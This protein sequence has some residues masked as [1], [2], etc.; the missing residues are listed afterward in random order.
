MAA[1]KNSAGLFWAEIL[2]RPNRKPLLL[3]SPMKWSVR[4]IGVVGHHTRVLSATFS[5]N[6][7]LEVDFKGRNF[8]ID[9]FQNQRTITTL[10]VQGWQWLNE[11]AH[12]LPPSCDNCRRGNL[13][14][15][16]HPTPWRQDTDINGNVLHIPK[17]TGQAA[18]RHERTLWEG[19]AALTALSAMLITNGVRTSY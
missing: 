10:A 3:K 18:R 13:F 9:A 11:L 12:W 4:G 16:L 8:R 19:N 2:D 14:K 17:M 15:Y 7:Y 1:T 6:I 5:A